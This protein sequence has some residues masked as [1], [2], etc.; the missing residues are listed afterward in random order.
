[1]SL[2]N[3]RTGWTCQPALVVALCDA[4]AYASPR[5]PYV[6]AIKHEGQQQTCVVSG[7]RANASRPYKYEYPYVLLSPEAT[8]IMGRVAVGTVV[9]QPQKAE[10]RSLTSETQ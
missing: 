10:S 7:V 5:S 2:A 3:G 6:G 4:A 9:T 8:T 1:M